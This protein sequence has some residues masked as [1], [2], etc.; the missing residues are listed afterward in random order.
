MNR[1]DLEARMRRLEKLVNGLGLEESLWLG[2][3]LGRGS[4]GRHSRNRRGDSWAGDGEGHGSLSVA[5]L[6]PSLGV[7]NVG[8]QSR[9]ARFFVDSAESPDDDTGT[10]P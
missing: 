4:A 6:L 9:S 8:R 5:V 7:G 1:L 10:E 3:S 2:A